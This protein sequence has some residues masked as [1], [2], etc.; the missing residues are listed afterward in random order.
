MLIRYG[1]AIYIISETE[2]PINLELMTI[3]DN[4]KSYMMSADLDIT[5]SDF[6]VTESD[7]ISY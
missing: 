2:D 6:S 5:L 4:M 1:H 3:C 7:D